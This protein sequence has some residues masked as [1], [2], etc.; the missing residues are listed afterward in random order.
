VRSGVVL[1]AVVVFASCSGGGDP[2]A[3]PHTLPL[4]E[5]PGRRLV[6]DDSAV[7]AETLAES[8]RTADTVERP[9]LP[10]PCVV[11][12]LEIWTSQV[13]VSAD[14]ADAVLRIRNPG[15]GWCEVGIGASP[16]IAPA[17]EPDVWLEPGDWADLV[18][19]QTPRE[20]DEPAPVT[21]AQIDINGEQLAVPTA[22][23]ASCGW[24]LTA[25]YPNE[26]PDGPCDAADLE[27]TVVS[28]H[29]LVR[30]SGLRSCE[31]GELDGPL[32]DTEAAPGV[33]ALAVGDV[34]AWPTMAAAECASS[35]RDLMFDVAAVMLEPIDGCVAIA[36]G[37]GR[38]Y[39][40]PDERPLGA[41]DPFDL[42]EAL[43]VLDPF[44][45]N[46]R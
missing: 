4:N 28:D 3:G 38:A 21:L 35:S 24:R 9:D 25:L 6:P 18:V 31:L 36:G 33:T 8:Q 22:A 46:V 43:A 1:V 42:D 23:V 16:Q 10:P 7:D 45:T 14:S 34:L 39:F 27:T 32:P 30:N 13:V 12:D 37:P 40:G 2:S 29:V 15:D 5:P 17:I 19:G 41:I 26:L 11:D 20:C 44:A